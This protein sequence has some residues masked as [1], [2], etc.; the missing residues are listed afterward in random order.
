VTAE[1][2]NRLGGL[3]DSVAQVLAQKY[4]APQEYVAVNDS[5]GESGTPAQLMEKYGLNSSSIV[6]AARKAVSRK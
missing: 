4:P 3:G 1:E 6:A 5:F 2:H